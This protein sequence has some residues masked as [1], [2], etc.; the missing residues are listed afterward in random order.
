[1]RVNINFVAPVAF[2]TIGTPPYNPFMIIDRKRGYEVHLP[3]QLPTSLADLTLLGTG[4][5][6][7]NIALSKYYVS[8]TYLPWAINLPISFNY[9][10]EK[11]DITKAHLVFNSWANSRGYSYMDWYQNRN[12]YRNSSKIYSH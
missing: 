5:D 1:M 8:D 4:Q 7:S 12:G 9:P 11:E 10:C 3:N 6:D 2:A